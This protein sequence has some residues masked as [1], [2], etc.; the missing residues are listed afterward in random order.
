MGTSR[1]APQGGTDMSMAPPL[2]TLALAIHLTV[3]GGW[4]GAVVAYLAL[5][6]AA[7]WSRDPQTVRAAW[8]A[9]ELTGW[10]VIVP[11][12]IASLMTGLVMALGTPWGLLRHYWT[13]LA[14]VLTVFAVVVLV[15]HMPTVSTRADAARDAEPALLDEIEGDLPHPAIGLGVLLGI[16]WLNVYKP[17]GMTPHGQ[18]KRYQRRAQLDTQPAAAP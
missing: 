11:L 7:D 18:R 17:R 14:L 3:A 10:F 16:Q 8:I 13:L 1:A 15:M 2:R 4:I 6:I 9:M 5:H 12:A